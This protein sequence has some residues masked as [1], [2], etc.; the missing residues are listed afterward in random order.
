MDS[1]ILALSMWEYY[2][3]F[4]GSD[5]KPMPIDDPKCNELLAAASDPV[6]FFRIAGL[7]E[8]MLTDGVFICKV[9]ACLS[10]IDRKGIRRAI[11][12]SL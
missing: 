5:G 3:I 7:S 12:E 10:A 1:V 9:K 4:R 8:N 6:A 11:A 2:F